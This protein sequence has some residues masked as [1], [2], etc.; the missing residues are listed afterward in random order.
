M[1]HDG[2]IGALG[3][4]FE[5]FSA[6]IKQHEPLNQEVSETNGEQNL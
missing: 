2:F 3:S 4:F 6:K 1:K 5:G